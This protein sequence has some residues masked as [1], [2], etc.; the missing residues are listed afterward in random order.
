ML[1]GISRGVYEFEALANDVLESSENIAN[2]NVG[3]PTYLGAQDGCYDGPGEE[4][5]CDAV[6]DYVPK[7]G[8]QAWV[9][10]VNGGIDIVCADSI[11]A[12]GDI[13]LN[14]QG[15]EIADAFLFSN[16]FIH[17]LG[18]FTVN[19]AGQIAATDTN[20]D[21][22]ALSVADLVYL[23]RVVVGDALPYAKLNPVGATYTADNGF[24]TVDQAMGAA[25]VVVAGNATPTLLAENMD[26]QYAFDGTNTRIL[27]SSM[28][29]NQTFNGSFIAVDGQVISVEMATYEGAPVVAK[30]LPSSYALAQNYPNP[31]NPATN[32][33]FSLKQAGDY[34]LTIYNVTGQTVEVFAGSAEAGTHTISWDASNQASGIYF[35][36]LSTDNFSDTKKMVLLK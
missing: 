31:F 21:G 34:T 5:W 17:G 25:Y 26:M 27:V 8:P 9:D 19:A 4:F 22:M 13:N 35:Y 2:P 20:A 33:A 12:R 10:F 30:A 24:V 15:Y 6:Q 14:N 11:D 32:I 7:P 16:Y 3:F 18:V 23:I 28:E 36:K 1:Q 29:A